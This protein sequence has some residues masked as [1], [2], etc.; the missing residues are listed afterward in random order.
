MGDIRCFK[1]VIQPSKPISMSSVITSDLAIGPNFDF[2][3]TIHTE[4][5]TFDCRLVDPSQLVF[6]MDT[7]I[8]TH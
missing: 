3:H 8:V 1:S 4:K 2:I 6:K 5:E 7:Q